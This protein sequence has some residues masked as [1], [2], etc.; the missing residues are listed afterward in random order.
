VNPNLVTSLHLV[1][2]L[3][4]VVLRGATDHLVTASIDADEVEVVPRPATD[5]VA[6]YLVEK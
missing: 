2:L 5:L 1:D 4:E 6:R 3:N